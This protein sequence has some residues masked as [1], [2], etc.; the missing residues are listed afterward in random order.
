MRQFQRATRTQIPGQRVIVR[1]ETVRP[2][3]D[4]VTLDI[5]DGEQC[6]DVVVATPTQARK[7]AAAIVAAADA[8]EK[9]K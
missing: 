7:I 8:A 1:S 3:G 9:G 2:S 5:Y 4:S 6:G